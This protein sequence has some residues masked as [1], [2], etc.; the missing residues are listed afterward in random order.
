MVGETGFRTSDPLLPK[1][2]RYQTAPLPVLQRVRVSLVASNRR[3]RSARF[4]DREKTPRNCPASS[5]ASLS[6]PPLMLRIAYPQ[7]TW[8]KEPKD[9][10]LRECNVRLGSRRGWRRA[11]DPGHRPPLDGPARYRQAP[12]T[13]GR[14]NSDEHAHLLWQD[15]HLARAASS[16]PGS[17]EPTSRRSFLHPPSIISAP[18]RLAGEEQETPS[19]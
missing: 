14:A 4:W 8:Q 11:S 5:P 18:E 19:A 7:A 10:L 13:R 1:Q 12:L 3:N 16:S 6:S 2:M 17:A 15:R 9:P